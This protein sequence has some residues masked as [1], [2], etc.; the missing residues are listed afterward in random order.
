VAA[1]DTSSST[2]A[3]DT[4]AEDRLPPPLSASFMNA[5]ATPGGPAAAV[6]IV[7]F[8]DVSVEFPRRRGAVLRDVE[9][10]LE[11]GEQLI[12]FG[13]SG[14][15]KSTLLQ[16]V[17]GVIPHS[18]AAR[19]S[20]S[21]QVAETDT[22]A[23]DAVELS[24]RVGVLAQDPTSAICL[25]DVDQEL[26]LPLENRAVDPT[27]ISGR[28]D[29]AL[30]AVHARDLRSR[31]TA[32]LS[33]GESQRVALAA[34]LIAE[35]DV[36]LLDEPT[37]MLDAEG[38]GSVREAIDR[39]TARYRP[40]VI[41]VEHRMD[42]YAGRR[43]LTGLPA[44][45]VVLNQQGRILFDGPTAEVLTNAAL[46]L[47]ARGCWLP[48]E[49]ELLAVFGSPGGLGTQRVR[50]GLR[51]MATGKHAATGRDVPP[52]EATPVLTARKLTVSRNPS[53]GRR[54]RTR[55]TAASVEGSSGGESGSGERPLVTNVDL[56]FRPGEIVALLGANGSGKTSLL[57]TL[58]GL[59]KP[60]AGQ[61][62][63]AR[64][65][66]IFQNPEHQFLAGTVRDEVGYGLGAEAGLLVEELLL[67]HRLDSLAEQSPF[68]LSGGEKRRLSVAAMLA[69]D[70]PVLLA[71]EPTFGLDRRAAIAMMRTFQ[72]EAAHGRVI[73]FSSHD[74]RTVATVAHRAVVIADG[75]VVAD[76]PVFE[77]LA[78][79]QML[80][81]ARMSLPPL[82]DWLLET[83]ET[84]AQMRGVLDGL[85]SAVPDTDE[86]QFS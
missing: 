36:L 54:S 12:V 73:V 19:L 66:M 57:L 33:G 56:A 85:N 67:R 14:A 60:A 35:P 48:L 69:H 21:V 40:A 70:R 7:V 28:I 72:D 51:G 23:T 50:I 26:A 64:P 10:Q 13:P 25:P 74:L 55:R 15:G 76:G 20:G 65:A 29:A 16:L 49:T 78:Q 46:A 68:Q 75:T 4:T 53:P 43:G 58:A 61:V 24:R 80:T 5:A 42:E 22:L 1:A 79:H 17:A 31:K 27:T 52:G 71:D 6:P 39:A 63:G 47:Q 41:L 59:L 30:D 3:R 83:F 62:I 37:S 38:I 82:L 34:S 45:A 18:V 84:P 32:Q 44:R 77:V 9:L 11:P 8:H 81:R 2:S 86:E